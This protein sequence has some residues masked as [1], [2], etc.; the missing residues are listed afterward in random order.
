[1]PLPLKVAAVADFITPKTMPALATDEMP[2]PEDWADQLRSHITKRDKVSAVVLA[3]FRK[4]LGDR[5]LAVK[6]K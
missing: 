5:T 1:M 6:T 4:G 3:E 2:I